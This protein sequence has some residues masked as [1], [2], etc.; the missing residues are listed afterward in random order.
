[1]AI[2]ELAAHAAA[3]APRHDFRFAQGL[4]ILAKVHGKGVEPLC[5]A[6]AEPKADQPIENSRGIEETSSIDDPRDPET[7]RVEGK[8]GQ[9]RGNQDP[10]EAAL[11]KA[12]E[13]A[14][15]AGRFD[16]VAQLAKE[17][18]ARRLAGMGN[19]HALDAKRE[20]R[21]K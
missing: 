17:L 15:A 2:P 19:V 12:L 1:M 18:E 8:E 21:R 5:L 16:V 13:G 7:T 4:P 20:E 9:S 10:V 3:I 6:A 14:A 11:A